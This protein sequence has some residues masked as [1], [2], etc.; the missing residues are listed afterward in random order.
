MNAYDIKGRWNEIKGKVREK[1]GQLTDDEMSR[2][3]GNYEQLVGLIEQKTGEPRMQIESFLTHLTEQGKSFVNQ[4]TDTVQEYA[5]QAADV[6]RSAA[7][8]ATDAARNRIQDTRRVVKRH[9]VES[10]AICFGVGM[11]VGA[12]LGLTLK[13]R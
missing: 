13:S 1:W 11:I 4:M 6:V 2:V 7:T 12:V 9:P 5:G 8:H 10:L 3:Q